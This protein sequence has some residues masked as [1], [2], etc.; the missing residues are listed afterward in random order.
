MPEREDIL[1][2]PS[3]SSRP[4]GQAQTSRAWEL[5]N[6]LQSESHPFAWVDLSS[7]PVLNLMCPSQLEMLFR[8]TIE[9]LRG[10]TW[11]EEG[12]TEDRSLHTSLC[13]LLGCDINSS[14]LSRAA[15]RM[16]FS[17]SNHCLNPL[18]PGPK[19]SLSFFQVC[20]SQ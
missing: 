14:P 6:V 15:I 7:L 18:R 11:L 17:P 2:P 5:I 13:F 16:L 1:S 9:T 20:L 8:D 12:V 10:K 4:L 19:I 3:P